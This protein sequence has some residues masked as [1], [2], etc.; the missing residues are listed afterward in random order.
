MAD[1]IPYGRQDINEEDI[2]AVVE[3]LRSPY[4]TTGPKVAEFEKAVAKKTGAPHAVAVSSG[5]AALHLAMLAA[6]IGAGDEV[7]VPTT[8]FLASANCILYA[9][10]QPVFVDSVADGFNLD[11]DDAERK[12]TKKTR[13]IIAVDFA[14]QPLDH[15]RL[16]TFAKKHGLLFIEDAAHA[17]GAT[18]QGRP[19]GS[20]ADMTILSFHPV[21]LITTGEGGMI[22][23]TEASLA[24][25]LRLLRHHGIDVDVQ[26]RDA[27]HSWMY[28]MT[29]LGFNY[30]LSDIQCA[31]GISQLKRLEAFIDRR[32]EIA[33]I[34]NQAFQGNPFLN[35]P[36]A[37]PET[38]RHAWH[39]Y[40]V[41][42]RLDRLKISRDGV[43][44]ELRE[45]GIGAHVHY[46]P[47]HLHPFY[48]K[49]GFQPGLCP[50]AERTF[51]TILTL[52][53]YPAMRETEIRR[54]IETVNETLGKHATKPVPVVHG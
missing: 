26:T 1:F 19:I 47:I 53:L 43:F 22:L 54:V 23:T 52:P 28:D 30:R 38:D 50:N 8:S 20:L 32:G 9:G 39:L 31:L 48:Q 46:R 49:L 45:E 24:K 36:P 21:K 42:L 15:D 29:E 35:I 34:Y 5:T 51:Q 37:G 3:V 13:A 2:N 4:L 44:K 11:L 10:A 18:N 7:L 6:G 40:I 16:R 27:Q 33:E 17:L 12:L 25:R 41:R 14:G